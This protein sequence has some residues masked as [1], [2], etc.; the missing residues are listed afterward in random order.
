MSRNSSSTRKK[1]SIKTSV[2]FYHNPRTS[3]QIPESKILYRYLKNYNRNLKN[4]ESQDSL[5]NPTNPVENTKFLCKSQDFIFNHI[6]GLCAYSISSILSSSSEYPLW[7][8]IFHRNHKTPIRTENFHRNH[9]ITFRFQEF[10]KTLTMN[11]EL[12]SEFS[13][14]YQNCFW[15][16]RFTTKFPVVQVIALDLVKYWIQACHRLFQNA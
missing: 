5:E 1:F 2:Y 15:N 6:I 7:N 13:S 10:F 12:L 16:S 3:I 8:I 14:T 4:S 11:P 9:S